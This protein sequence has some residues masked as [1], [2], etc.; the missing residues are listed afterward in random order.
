MAGALMAWALLAAPPAAAIVESE[1]QHDN[2]QAADAEAAFS[3]AFS[4][5]ALDQQA[6]Q[7]FLDMASRSAHSSGDRQKRMTVD[8]AIAQERDMDISI[9]D[10]F[11]AHVEEERS[12]PSLRELA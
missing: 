7:G 9:S 5:A 6:Y 3:S 2:S 11:Q 12:A 4:T 1:K 8:E 10:V